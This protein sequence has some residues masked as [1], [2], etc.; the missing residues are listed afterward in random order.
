M[1]ALPAGRLLPLLHLCDSLFPTGA[2]AHSDGLETAA[3]DGLVRDAA[4]LRDW[5]EACLDDAIE[6]CEGP[7]VRSAWRRFALRDWTGL[8]ELEAD[9]HALRP[10][11]TARRATR[12]MGSRLLKTWQH[13]HPDADLARLIE[14][15]PATGVALPVAFGIVCAA[16]EID[17][18]AALSGF[19][20]T[21][22]AA[23]ISSAMRLMPIGQNEA[24]A[25]LAS[26]IERIPPV[27]DHICRSAEPSCSF[28]PA[29]DLALM[30]QQYVHSRLFRS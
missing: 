16:A 14:T 2:F 24:H 19:I 7:A 8:H 21:R 3:A 23:T 25:V 9:V 10:S 11:S 28:A 6:R 12:A 1:T 5:M 13:L 18:E 29:M 4:T 22:L 26:I 30:S 17:L 27:V 15:A 20:Y